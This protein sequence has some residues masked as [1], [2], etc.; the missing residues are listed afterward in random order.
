VNNDLVSLIV[1]LFRE[2]CQEKEIELPEDVGSETSLFG[3]DGILDSLG[4]VSLIIA[5]E[6]AIDD[7]FGVSI[8][9]A[10]EKAMS[11]KKSPYRTI[12]RLAEYT[13]RLIQ[14]EI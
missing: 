7:K 2:V 8:S 3:R 9:L 4:L 14:G 1:E 5:L 12:G 11:Q 10:D 6:Q 13:D